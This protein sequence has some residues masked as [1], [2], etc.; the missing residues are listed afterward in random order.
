M[1]L[2]QPFSMFSRAHGN[3]AECPQLTTENPP[4][5]P[6]LTTENT[7]ESPQHNA[8]QEQPPKKRFKTVTDEDIECIA[9]KT[10]EATTNQ[11]TKWAIKLFKGA[12]FES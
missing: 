11:M 5:S 7:P 8:E 6:K 1:E 3:P 10:T 9:S 4:D 2:F 12:Y